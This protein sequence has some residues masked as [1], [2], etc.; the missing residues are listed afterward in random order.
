MN[1]S[2]RIIDKRNISDKLFNLI[3]NARV[4]DLIEYLDDLPD[5]LKIAKIS[6]RKW[7]GYGVLHKAAS[8]G[9]TDLCK[10]FLD[11]GIKI[12]EISTRGMLAFIYVPLPWK[13]LNHTFVNI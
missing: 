6:Y 1:K 13:A 8:L 3:E 7:S 10:L 12:D 4:E 9:R 2:N 5:E 11:N